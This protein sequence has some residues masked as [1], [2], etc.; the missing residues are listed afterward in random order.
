MRVT[1]KPASMRS[2]F[3]PGGWLAGHHPNYEFRPGQL[4][5]AEL[6][7]TAFR[8]KRH[9]LVEAGTGTGKTLAYLV[10]ALLSG[11]RVVVSTFTKNLQEQ[12]FF[13]DIPF[14]GRHLGG[15]I[16]ACYMK[17]RNNY[18]CRQRLYEAARQGAPEE[19]EQPGELAMIG[20]WEP[21][22]QTGDR[23]ELPGLPDHSTLWPRLDARRD[24]CLGQKCPQLD[25]CFLTEMRRRALES[26]LVIVNHHLFFADL[27]LKQ[28]DAPGLGI[29]PDYSAVI[30]DEAHEIEEVVS[31]YFGVS[32]SSY[33]VED[34]A[35][36]C[37]VV[38]RV[39]QCGS[40]ELFQ[41]AARMRE[42]VGFLF[43]L[44]AG[45]DG[46]AA[47]DNRSEFVERHATAWVSAA[48]SLE[49][50][51]SALAAMPEKPEEVHRLVGRVAELRRDLSFLLEETSRAYVYWVERRGR[52]I[53]LQATPIDVAPI[54]TGTLFEQVEA[55]VLTSATLSVAG[56]F[57]Y[58]RRRLGV[59]YGRER[60]LDSHFDYGRQAL[61]YLPSGL[62]DP[63]RPDFSTKAAEEVC[64]IL[65]ATRGRAFVL[66]TSYQ[67]MNQVYE[68]AAPRLRFPLLLQGTAPRSALLER[69]RT[70]QNAVLFA[71]SSFWQGVDVPGQQLSCVII[72]RLPFA[73]PT[74]PVVAARSRLLAE[75]GGNPFLDYQVPQAVL[76]LKQGFGRLIRS[77]SDRGILAI[78]DSR[79]LTKNYGTIFLE[80]LPGYRVTRDVSELERFMANS[81]G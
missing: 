71:T 2:F 18:L 46:R 42:R 33:R 63:R 73:V 8:E 77:R 41:A 17:G 11:R 55:C 68:S 5:M 6:V 12:L 75:E 80:S 53:F 67:Q 16:R 59:R 56:S 22:T 81:P 62:P 4:E 51:G 40:P 78:L 61:L 26:D 45:E 24:T 65:E 3:G 13:K 49:A 34:L 54:L 37:E 27:A 43:G 50:L 58:I 14:L 35:R 79:I 7:Q 69:F 70:L 19:I 66:F 32:A 15:E 9:L 60:A 52:G 31:Q 57:E 25:R 36:D 30:F 47:F 1:D 28:R 64:R 72:D 48:G 20:E 76:A 21:H 29:I 38:L 74:D 44:L 23:A 10:P 39:H